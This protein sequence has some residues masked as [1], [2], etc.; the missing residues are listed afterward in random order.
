MPN[1]DV[2][3]PKGYREA[4]VRKSSYVTAPGKQTK[5][6]AKRKHTKQVSEV[7]DQGNNAKGKTSTANI[8][9][10]DQMPAAQVEE[11]MQ[12]TVQFTGDDE[13]S[14]KTQEDCQQAAQPKPVWINVYKQED[15]SQP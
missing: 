11:K 15:Q 6:P 4:T 5:S 10:G 13:K 8:V 1:V 3:V 12:K 2:P 14:K 7:D 9:R